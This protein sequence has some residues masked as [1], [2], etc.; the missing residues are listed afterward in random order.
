MNPSLCQCLAEVEDLLWRMIRGVYRFTFVRVPEW[1][2]HTL[3]DTVGPVTIRLMRVLVALCLW[4]A[5]VFGPSI[6]TFKI[7][8]GF[9]GGVAALTW[10]A[11]ATSG[12]IWGASYIRKKRRAAREEEAGYVSCI[13]SPVCVR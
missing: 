4:L 2:Y 8:G 13:A 1:M 11:L 5:T 9:W 12:S 10:L 3:V 6:A 7:V